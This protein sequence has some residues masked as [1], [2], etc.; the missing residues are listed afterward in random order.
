LNDLGQYQNSDTRIQGRALEG[1]VAWHRAGTEVS[2]GLGWY[3]WTSG[4]IHLANVSAWNGLLKAIHRVGAWSLAAEASYVDGRQDTGSDTNVPPNWTLRASL[5]YDVQ[6]FWGQI[7]L[8]DATNSR[9]R[10]LVAPEYDPITWM[11]NDGRAA[12]LT[13]GFRL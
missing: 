9:R 5:R 2:G 1:E 3:D 8:E 11:Q 12:R 7:T 6:R 10:D 4:G 13:M